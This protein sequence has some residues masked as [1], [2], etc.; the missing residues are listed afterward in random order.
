MSPWLHIV[1]AG[2]SI[3]RKGKPVELTEVNTGASFHVFQASR[4]M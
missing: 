1:I 2:K 4:D 3:L